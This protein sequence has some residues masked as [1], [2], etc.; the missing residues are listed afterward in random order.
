M[1][2][3]KEDI[4]PKKL[5]NN[6]LAFVANDETWTEPKKVFTSIKELSSQFPFKKIRI[7][8]Y[9]VFQL[10]RDYGYGTNTLHF[11]L[12][13]SLEVSPCGNRKEV[14]IT[15]NQTFWE[16]VIKIREA[17][18]IEIDTGGVRGGLNGVK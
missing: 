15:L 13:N 14:H 16:W 12:I 3:K 9:Y 5:F 1:T 8:F 11:P 18:G 10:E 17:A 2:L 4:I 7:I 6:F